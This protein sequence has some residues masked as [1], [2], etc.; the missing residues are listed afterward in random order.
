MLYKWH[1]VKW[2]LGSN[3]NV[4]KHALAPPIKLNC[5]AMNGTKYKHALETFLWK[6]QMIYAKM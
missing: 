4:L 5:N 6:L 1:Q 3:I 2:A